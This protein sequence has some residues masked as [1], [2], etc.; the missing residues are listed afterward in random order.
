MVMGLKIVF[1]LYLR[2]ETK[3]ISTMKKIYLIL[4]LL[5]R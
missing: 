2:V 3:T 1:A 5:A 4:L